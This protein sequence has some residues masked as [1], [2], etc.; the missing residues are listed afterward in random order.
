MPAPSDLD[1]LYREHERLRS[2]VRALIALL[3]HHLERW[4][5]A[6]DPGNRVFT[7]T[8]AWAAAQVTRGFDVLELPPAD[9]IESPTD[10][11]NAAN[12]RLWET[13]PWEDR[14]G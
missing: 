4:P 5:A 9:L 6:E 3:Q 8:L 14:D 2:A 13:S 1:A 10:R 7:D 12:E 11:W